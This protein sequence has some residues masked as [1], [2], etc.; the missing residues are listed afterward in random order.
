[1]PDSAQ[2]YQKSLGYLVQKAGVGSRQVFKYS[3][4][5][6]PDSTGIICIDYY[7]FLLSDVSAGYLVKSAVA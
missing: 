5:N 7:D 4:N 2:K 6:P 3:V 1:V